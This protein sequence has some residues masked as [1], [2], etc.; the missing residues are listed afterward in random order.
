MRR[1]RVLSAATALTATALSVSLLAF[2]A[3]SSATPR[4]A[5]APA[6][7]AV[8]PAALGEPASPI[9]VAT[10]DPSIYRPHAGDSPA[11]A[12]LRANL[13]RLAAAY[14]TAG[15]LYNRALDT[16]QQTERQLVTARS[17]LLAAEQASATA[18]RQ[19]QRLLSIEYQTYAPFASVSPLFTAPDQSSLADRL[20][21]MRRLSIT[22]AAVLQNASAAQAA[23]AAA[24]AKVDALQKR[25]AAALESARMMR[26]AAA[27]A[28]LD[29]QALL[30]STQAAELAAALRAAA[31]GPIGGGSGSSTD[32][33]VQLRAQALS[34]GAAQPKDFLHVTTAVAVIAVSVR[35]LLRQAAGIGPAPQRGAGR[36]V[37]ISFTPSA[38][39]PVDETAVMGPAP[40]L[41]GISAYAVAAGSPTAARALTRFE[42]DPAP[43]QPSAGA[44]PGP[45]AP[46]LAANGVTVHPALPALVRGQH[47]RAEIAVDT[48]LSEI[49]SPYVWGAAGPNTFDCSGLTQWAWGS[50]GVSLAHFAG[51]QLT[52]GVRVAVNQ[53]LPGDLIMFGADLHHV[54]MYLGA[55]YMVD[56]PH[57]GAYVRIEKVASFGDFAAAVRP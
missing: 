33:A 11:V 24:A 36:G 7:P 43:Q 39:M 50:A 14:E 21:T 4:A 28:V 34:T 52:E 19:L 44:D 55:G 57:T 27:K 22:K 56:A 51:T 41:G 40:A 26:N 16:E 9:N 42:G 45:V 32:A 12:G 30:A 13:A 18:T 54:G 46:T 53:L 35:A 10:L 8:T 47:L 25:S 31:T 17:D 38:T 15:Q 2:P 6:S 3:V 37:G 23:A 49:G 29:G 1:R 20:E 48:A 5:I